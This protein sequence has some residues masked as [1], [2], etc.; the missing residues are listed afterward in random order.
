MKTITKIFEAAIKKN[1]EKG[2]KN[3]YVAIDV[4]GTIFKPTK[5][6]HLIHADGGDKPHEVVCSY[7][8]TPEFQFY[9]FAKECL[10]K[11]SAMPNVKLILW[12]SAIYQ[13][14]IVK[15]LNS[16]GIKIY[17]VNHNPDFAHNCSTQEIYAD[18]ST[19]FYFDILL[20]DKAGFD[21]QNDW[22]ELY[23][24]LEK[25]SREEYE[26]DLEEYRQELAK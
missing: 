4:H 24:F 22:E 2:Y 19:K 10:T 8:V 6:T 25:K 16:F 14:E 18:F 5:Q 20:D 21:P 15:K 9:W 23:R 13:N 1:E 26:K 17:A 11:L 7:G 3:L 12:T